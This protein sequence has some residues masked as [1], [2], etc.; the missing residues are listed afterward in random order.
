VAFTIVTGMPRATSCLV[1]VPCKPLV[2]TDS[3]AV[4]T[5]TKAGYMARRGSAYHFARVRLNIMPVITILTNAQWRKSSLET[6]GGRSPIVQGLLRQRS[7]KKLADK[8]TARFD[9]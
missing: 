1:L 4:L 6:D 5:C 8:G 7:R 9:C 2:T 3:F